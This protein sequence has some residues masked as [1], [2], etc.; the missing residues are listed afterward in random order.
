MKKFTIYIATMLVML[1]AA[2][3]AQ[4]EV[5]TIVEQQRKLTLT[6]N[7][8][9]SRSRALAE[10]ALNMAENKV[11]RADVFFFD[12]NGTY[13]FHQLGL[14]PTTPTQVDGSWK[15]NVN[16][17]VPSGITFNG[18]TYQVYVLGN[19]QVA[20]DGLVEKVT[21]LGTGATIESL[22]ALTFTS[23]LET[24]I[25]E[26]TRFIMDGV[27]DVTISAKQEVDGEIP[28]VRAAAKVGLNLEVFESIE[29][30]D[31]KTY[32][33]AP[34]S[35]KVSYHN[36]VKTFG[37]TSAEFFKTEQWEGAAT[38]ETAEGGVYQVAIDPF[39]SYPLSWDE[40]SD[41][42]PYMMLQMNWG[43][44]SGSD[45]DYVPYYYRI[46]VNRKFTN[47]DGDLALERNNAYLINL[48]I[49]VL[50]S[51]DPGQVVTLESEYEIMDWGALPINTEVR[52]YK[53]LVVDQEE[54]S[55][56]NQTNAEVTFA[57]SHDVTVTIDKIEYEYYGRAT[58]RNITITSD[59]RTVT[60]QINNFN[61]G[62][63]YADYKV[64]NNSGSVNLSK[65]A[66]KVEFTHT[67][68]ANTYV[69][70]TI[71]ITVKH[72]GDTDG[73][74]AQQVKIKQYPPIYI[75]GAQSN[76]KVF[77]N[78]KTYSGNSTSVSVS[79]DN[80]SGIGSVARPNGISGDDD[81]VNENKNQYNVYVT[82]LPSGSDAVIGDPR[83]TTGGQLNGINELSQYR[84]TRTDA[85]N[86]IAPVFKIASSYGKTTQMSY[87]AAK[88]R[89]ASYQENGYPAGRWRIPTPAEIEFMQ[90]RALN[91]DIPSLF[92]GTNDSDNWRYP[93]YRGY[94][95]G[96]GQLYWPGYDADGDD[97][98]PDPGF[99]TAGANSFNSSQSV[100]CVYDVWYWGDENTGQVSGQNNNY[101]LTNAV[102]GDE[103]TVKTK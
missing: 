27:D 9:D 6:F 83:E 103:G 54:I 61:D 15:M 80:N 32:V 90:E 57:S 11:D 68:T 31:G 39:Y 73:E 72:T 26:A 60:P 44:Q 91:G 22:Q 102:W 96:N 100:R 92:N 30:E 51:T 52:D 7:M 71:Y 69:P 45:I 82:V 16:V 18:G 95:A 89:C 49:G 37:V 33:P 42:E 76:G 59:G 99:Y 98:G 1:M 43:V 5:E 19:A 36:G 28:L 12:N 4:E 81:A 21:G 8:E 58:T 77:V 56:Y 10:D 48:E 25:T 2:S 62:N 3:C 87:D 75:I 46:P 29:G 20:S 84:A 35:V 17:T 41:H 93:A 38:S 70:H 55:I 74:Y 79:D 86:V 66:G 47:E 53:Y 65:D 97:Y 23:A 78:E 13:L 88:K 85:E 24:Q 50:G 101:Q 94:W 67:M 63:Q 64:N 14:V 40:E 34:N